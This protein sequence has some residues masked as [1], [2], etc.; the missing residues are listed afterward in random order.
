MN[1]AVPTG[2]A[3]R[4]KTVF[5]SVCE[6]LNRPLDS[7]TPEEH[8]R[9]LLARLAH[10]VRRH[11]DE[12]AVQGVTYRDVLFEM[13]QRMAAY[14]ARYRD[15]S[16][17]ESKQR[18]VSAMQ[19]RVTEQVSSLVA[20]GEVAPRTAVVFVS[21]WPSLSSIGDYGTIVRS[22]TRIDQSDLMARCQ[23]F[24]GEVNRIASSYAGGATQQINDFLHVNPHLARRVTSRIYVSARLDGTPEKAI[25]SWWCA[26]RQAG[27]QNEVYFKVA[28]RLSRRFD[29]I[30]LFQTTKTTD[31]Q[32]EHLVSEFRKKCAPAW[33]EETDAPTGVPLQLG[34]CIA[35]EPATINTFARYAG[36]RNRISYN[37]LI[38]AVG[39]LAFVLACA[40]ARQEEA[41]SP[42]PERLTRLAPAA[43][44]YFE[45]LIKLS[46][47]NPETMAAP[48]LG[49][50]WP[51]WMKAF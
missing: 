37:Q 15:D 17:F 42:A 39:E 41:G 18:H 33:L 20:Q 13:S 48:L 3:Q 10:G 38:A 22:G 36:S 30:V 35:P 46:D 27:L 29:S 2:R 25:A 47:I 32:V 45:Q 4:W 44:V 1:Y 9:R 26:V 43:A 23:A 14:V 5:S 31:A 40:D 6:R 24:A 12:P 7:T 51:A 28:A 11:V 34:I 8:C 49:G 19:S 16:R 50:R 21:M